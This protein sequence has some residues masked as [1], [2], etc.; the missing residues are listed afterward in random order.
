MHVRLITIA[1]FAQGLLLAL[2]VWELLATYQT[3]CYS[4]NTL[5]SLRPIGAIPPADLP[6]DLKT[7]PTRGRQWRRGRRGGI[8][9]RLRRRGNRPPLPSL[10]LSNTRSLKSKME[11]LHVNS[12]VCFEYRESSVMVFT[13]T[14][15]HQDILDSH[16]E[17]EGFSLIRPD[18]TELS[19]KSQGG[20]VCLFVNDSW[21]RNYTVRDTVCTADIELLC[22]SL[23]PHYLPREFGNVLICTVYVPPS[24]NAAKAAIRISNVH[25]EP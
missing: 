16:F 11:E 9:Q 5:M 12:K 6:D 3:L 18:R 7:Q 25:P 24:G 17:P 13:E 19:G 21:C 4:K 8:W 10:L 22:L 2:I 14:W 15:F 23:R 20:G 1:T